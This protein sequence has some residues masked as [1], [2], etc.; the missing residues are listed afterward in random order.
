MSAALGACGG[1]FLLGARLSLADLMLWPFVERMCILK[2]YRGFELP[3]EEPSFAAFRAW[4]QAV[5]G[6][7]SVQEARQQEAFF[8]EGYKVYANPP[9]Q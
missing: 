7:R 4:A 6:L 3:A 2:H 9:P 8:V 5:G 1:P